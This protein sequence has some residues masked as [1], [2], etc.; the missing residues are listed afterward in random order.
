MYT[1][2]RSVIFSYLEADFGDFC[3]V[4]SL[5][6]STFVSFKSGDQVL[7]NISSILLLAF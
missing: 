3:F 4:C 6:F 1:L 5:F 2:Y 7:A